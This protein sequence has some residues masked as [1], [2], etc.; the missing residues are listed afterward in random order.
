MQGKNEEK[1]K[2]AGTGS[3]SALAGTGTV[4][5]ERMYDLFEWQAQCAKADRIGVS[6]GGRQLYA[7][8]CQ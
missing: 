7:G 5:K 2:Q 3:E 4:R 8:L 6:E 1:R